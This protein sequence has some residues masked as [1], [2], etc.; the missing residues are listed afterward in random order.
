MFPYDC[1]SIKALFYSSAKMISSPTI[2]ES[3]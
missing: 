1:T 2:S 3:G